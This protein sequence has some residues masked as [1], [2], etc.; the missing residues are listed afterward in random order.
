MSLADRD[1]ACLWDML[2]IAREVHAMMRLH[3]LESFLQDRI[4][5]LALERCMEILGEAAR[6]VSETTRNSASDIAWKKIIGMRNLL[7]HEYGHVDHVLL[8]NTATRDIPQLI[9]ALVVLL[10]DPE[11]AVDLSAFDERAADP[12]ITLAELLESIRKPGKDGS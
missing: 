10:P 7:A 2:R 3:E 1:S 12:E 6:Q 5:Q 8:Y 4:L 11:T 9:A